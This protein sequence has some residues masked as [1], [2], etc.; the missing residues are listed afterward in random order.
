[1]IEVI[2]KNYLDTVIRDVP[3]VFEVPETFPDKLITLER[4]GGSVSNHV[5]HASFAI[6]SW[7]GSL[8]DAALLDER[9]RLA[10]DQMADNTKVGGCHMASNYNFTDERTK[11]YRY[12]CTYEIYYVED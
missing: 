11:R 8:Y 5:R 12:Q 4:I 1:M 3:V 9:V 2:L 7:A 6:Q 10:M